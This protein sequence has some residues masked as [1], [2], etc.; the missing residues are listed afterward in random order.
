MVVISSLWWLKRANAHETLSPCMPDPWQELIHQPIN[1]FSLSSSSEVR[2]GSGTLQETA[3][4]PVFFN[5]LSLCS[6]SPT[7]REWQRGR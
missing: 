7:G 2:K 1:G 6:T 3:T 5:E 4:S